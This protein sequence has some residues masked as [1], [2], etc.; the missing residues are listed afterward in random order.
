MRV[1]EFYRLRQCFHRV[2]GLKGHAD[3]AAQYHLAV[4]VHQKTDV[5]E[6]ALTVNALQGY[7]GDV[8]DDYFAKTRRYEFFHNIGIRRI[9][10]AGV[11][12]TH[13]ASAA[14]LESISVE[15]VAE[16]IAADTVAVRERAAVHR[17]HLHPSDA[18]ILGLDFP[19]ELYGK[20]FQ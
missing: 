17:P 18:G 3:A 6:S 14:Y 13:S 16:A 20:L 8:S 12:C 2:F 9:V 1:K 11:C 4:G 10:V 19:D 15:D 5:A 7:I